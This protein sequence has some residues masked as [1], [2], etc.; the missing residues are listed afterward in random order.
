MFWNI[1]SEQT[2]DADYFTLFSP[3]QYPQEII[4]IAS[5]V[6]G[7]TKKTFAP[8]AKHGVTNTPS[9]NLPHITA[10]SI[11][12]FTRLS[13]ST[14]LYNTLVPL[15]TLRQYSKIPSGPT[16]PFLLHFPYIY[17]HKIKKTKWFRK[18]SLIHLQVI[19]PYICVHLFP[20]VVRHMSPNSL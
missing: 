8:N 19:Q 4:I 5:G 2:R 13:G 3:K 6:L 20:Q 10:F 16:I 14:L 11:Y 12:F 7:F 17:K 18:N 1:F 9:H 15:I